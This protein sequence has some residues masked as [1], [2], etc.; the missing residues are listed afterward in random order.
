MT[1]EIQKDQ[2]PW[3]HL[4]ADINSEL[5]VDHQEL[6]AT[7]QL[8]QAELAKQTQVVQTQQAAIQHQR[9][10][11]AEM[12][13][14][15]TKTFDTLSAKLKELTDEN[16]TLVERTQK[17]EQINKLTAQQSKDQQELLDLT[18]QK[19]ESQ[20]ELLAA[21][22]EELQKHNDEAQNELVYQII[23]N[24]V[25]NHKA[26]LSQADSREKTFQNILVW[27]HQRKNVVKYLRR[28]KLVPKVS[29]DLENILF[30]DEKTL[31][32]LMNHLTF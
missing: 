32:D 10:R 1:K 22:T 8:T 31:N 24:H 21:A 5:P 4:F 9:E 13:S 16:A 15:S 6:L 29:D 12:Q 26:G 18:N 20:K 3:S 19:M 17:L 30:V 28:N 23:I 14:I 7:Q 11:L 2:Y 27:L 25:I